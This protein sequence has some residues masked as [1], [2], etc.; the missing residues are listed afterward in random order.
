MTS[1]IILD[2]HTFNTDTTLQAQYG[3]GGSDL[4]KQS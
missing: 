1:D 4:T 2:A 3:G